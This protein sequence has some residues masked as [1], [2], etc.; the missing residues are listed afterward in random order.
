MGKNEKAFEI[1][2]LAIIVLCVLAV[3]FSLYRNGRIGFSPTLL[4]VCTLCALIIPVS[5]DYTLPMLAAPI[6]IFLGSLPGLGGSSGRKVVSVLL[7]LVASISYASLLY[8]FKYKPY[9]LNNSFPPL[10]LLLIAVTLFY[11]LQGRY[12]LDNASLPDQ[13]ES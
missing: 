11:F 5:V 7:I 2:L 9:F 4:L 3:V 8:P 12:R 6:A 13:V 1:A 10:F